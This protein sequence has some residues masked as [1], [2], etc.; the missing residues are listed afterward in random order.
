MTAFS[1]T[2]RRLKSFWIDG[3]YLTEPTGSTYAQDG[4]SK[5]ELQHLQR[6]QKYSDDFEIYSPENSDGSPDWPTKIMLIVLIGIIPVLLL[7]RF[8]LWR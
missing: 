7:V 1:T 5:K 8:V 3:I 2:L 6:L 4:M